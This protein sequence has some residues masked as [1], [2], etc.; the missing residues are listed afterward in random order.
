MQ[1][2]HRELSPVRD[3][4]IHDS[5]KPETAHHTVVCPSHGGLLLTNIKKPLVV[6]TARIILKNI[7]L[8]NTLQIQKSTYCMIHLGEILEQ[9]KLIDGGIKSEQSLLSTGKGHKGTLLE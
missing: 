9:E 6:A 3:S 5:P 7:M 1:E 8:T 2:I 4:F